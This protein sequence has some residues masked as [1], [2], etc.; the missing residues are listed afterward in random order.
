MLKCLQGLS[1]KDLVLGTSIESPTG[2]IK[3]GEGNPGWMPIMDFFSRYRQFFFFVYITFNLMFIL[4]GSN[5]NNLTL[6]KIRV[7]VL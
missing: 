3:E 2:V 7:T 6:K 5:L 1:L 4:F